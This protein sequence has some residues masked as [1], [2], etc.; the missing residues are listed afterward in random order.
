MKK[1]FTPMKKK[2]TRGVM[3]G[4]PLTQEG[5]CQV[6]NQASHQCCGSKYIEFGS[7]SKNLAQFG[8]GSRSGSGSRVMLPVIVNNLKE[9]TKNNLEFFFFS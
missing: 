1:A 8:C 7:G 9:K 3:D 6:N 2:A 4:V 5:V